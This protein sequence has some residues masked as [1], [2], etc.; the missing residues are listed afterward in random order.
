MTVTPNHAGAAPAPCVTVLLPADPPRSLGSIGLMKSLPIFIGISMTIFSSALLG[1]APTPRILEQPGDSRSVHVYGQVRS[2]GFVP[3]T[4]KLTLSDAIKA[5]GGFSCL[6]YFIFV[7]PPRS[8]GMDTDS[9]R[10]KTT[11][12]VHAYQ[13]DDTIKAMKVPPG[14]EVDVEPSI[15]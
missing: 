8:D 11:I 14:G 4:E 15:D 10:V 3:W 12:R 5:A 1:G 9:P 7:Y 6:A 2:G 13:T